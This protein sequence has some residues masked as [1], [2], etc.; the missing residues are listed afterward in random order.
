[1]KSVVSTLFASAALL[2]VLSSVA[3][4]ATQD[5]STTP[6]CQ[7]PKTYCNVFFGQ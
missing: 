1:M 2:V 6:Q 5:S 3:N 7:G 4:A